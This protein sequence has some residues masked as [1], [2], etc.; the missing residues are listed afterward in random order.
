MVFPAR[1]VFLLPLPEALGE[2]QG[3]LRPQRGTVLERSE[4]EDGDG[5]GAETS[6]PAEGERNDSTNSVRQI[7]NIGDRKFGCDA[8]SYVLP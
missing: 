7:V 8:E 1:V 6:V 4:L 3:G 2:E 5:L